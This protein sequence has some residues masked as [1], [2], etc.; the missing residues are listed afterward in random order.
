MKKIVSDWSKLS[1][2]TGTILER[3]DINGRDMKLIIGEVLDIPYF[4]GIITEEI[5]KEILCYQNSKDNEGYFSAVR[6][7]NKLTIRFLKRAF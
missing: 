1:D 4:K 7:D 3:V 2:A 6:E 5:A